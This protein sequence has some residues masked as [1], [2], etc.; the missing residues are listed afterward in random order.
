MIK[1]NLTSA[2]VA[3]L[4]TGAPLLAEAGA[5]QLICANTITGD[6][7]VGNKCPR[8]FTPVNAGNLMD[9][10]APVQ[11]LCFNQ[12]A[13]AFRVA[14]QCPTGSIPVSSGNIQEVVGSPQGF[15]S[16]CHTV[17]NTEY[18][19]NGTSVVDIACGANEFMLN[20]GEYPTPI[21]L[22]FI[23]WSEITYDGNVPTGVSVVAQSEIET[24]P[25]FESW[26]FT[27][28]GTC[29]PRQFQ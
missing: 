7:R 1:K 26:S 10:V 9:V 5:K 27:V 14:K 3:A 6:L 20:Y 4:V 17:Q 21:S 18:T 16:Q 22:D 24:T 8:G 13:G 23:R 11:L 28:T 19:T 29:C 12:T 25:A 2:I 15:I